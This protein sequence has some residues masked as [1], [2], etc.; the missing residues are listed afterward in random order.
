[1]Q[2]LCRRTYELLRTHPALWLPYLVAE[3]LAIFLWQLWGMAREG[4]F[5][6]FTT[7]HSVLGGNLSAPRDNY[8]A[9]DR[10]SIVGLP[11][12]LATVLV[13]VCLFVAALVATAAMVNSIGREQKLDASE[14]LGGV[15]QRWRA[16]LLFALRFLIVFGVIGAGTTAVF[17]FALRMTHR[18]DLHT[19]Y[20]SNSGMM[21]VWVGCAAWLVMPAVIRLLR[22]DAAGMLSTQSRNR[23]TVI[24]I[25]VSE[26]GVALGAI[27]QKLEAPMVLDAHWEFKALGVLNS[28]L[29]NA[30]DVVLFIALALLAADYSRESENN[31]RSKIH[32]LL[33]ALMPLHFHPDKES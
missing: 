12:G 11:L 28:I 17:F 18:E 16:I 15:A 31:K 14:I 33:Q 6:W 32:E 9:L 3:L 23:G 21:L 5:K 4:I 30:P 22:G 1:M 13:V 29:A 24:A 20:V 8:A 27:A 26:A 2:E 19:W 10:A 7:G 25:L